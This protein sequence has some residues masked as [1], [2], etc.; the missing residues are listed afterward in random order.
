MY[1]D[2]S[3]RD[4]KDEVKSPRALRAQQKAI[5]KQKMNANFGKGSDDVVVMEPV[6]ANRGPKEINAIEDSPEPPTNIPNEG[7]PVLNMMQVP[8][9]D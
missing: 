6:S 2:T 3:K 8:D 1:G 9:D 5:F 4:K 7:S